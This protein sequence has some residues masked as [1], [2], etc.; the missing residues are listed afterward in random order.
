MVLTYALAGLLIGLSVLLL[1]W[2]L[3]SWRTA[4]HGGLTEKHYQF[5][6]RQFG[7]RVAASGLIGLIGLLMAADSW[8]VHP[9]AKLAYWSG[10][11]ALVVVTMLLALADW[12]ASRAHLGPM[13]ATH[14]AERAALQAEIDRYHREREQG[15]A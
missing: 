13:V 15:E 6:R 5:H 1:A 12:L 8:I 3:R 9:I 4:D 7:R 14:A 2:H 11:A 10:I